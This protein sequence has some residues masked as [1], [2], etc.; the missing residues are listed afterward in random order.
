VADARV[1]IEIINDKIKL[2]TGTSKDKINLVAYQKYFEF[3][4]KLGL[5][6]EFT[7]YTTQDNLTLSAAR[8]Q[9]VLVNE[10]NHKLVIVCHGVTNNK[11]SLFYTMHLALQMGYQVVTYDARNHGLSDKSYNNL[12]QIE[13]S[14]LQDII[15]YVRQKY[16]PKKIGLYGFSMGATT[17]LF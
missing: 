8:I 2:L 15:N 5:K 17:L 9:P 7:V 10:N 1:S 3:L 6:E 14:D 16:Q 4:D 12:G 13:A 11:W